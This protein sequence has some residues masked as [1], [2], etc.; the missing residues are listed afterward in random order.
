M[1]CCQ[2]GSWRQGQRAPTKD[3]RFSFGGRRRSGAARELGASAARAQRKSA[4]GPQALPSRVIVLLD[5]GPL[6][7]LS[8]PNVGKNRDLHRWVRD[9]I[10]NDSRV[11]VP[12]IADYEV[13][14]E[15]IRADKAEG[16]GKLDALK[17]GILEYLPLTT[18]AMERAARFWAESRQRGLPTC[19]ARCGRDSRRASGDSSRRGQRRH[20]YDECGR[21]GSV[22]C[23]EA[24]AGCPV[25][26]RTETLRRR[27]ERIADANLLH[28]T[29]PVP[30]VPGSSV[31][32]AFG[33]NN[34][35]SSGN[36]RVK[37]G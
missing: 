17:L 9:L 7:M 29:G 23:G 30:V 4:V 21:P 25:A 36:R 3:A 33:C 18:R 26:P 32:R 19:R 11:V 12:E 1:R 6:G 37:S 5:A 22:R 8:H 28:Y 20:R 24:V 15:L 14:R 35:A 10:R 13:R 2:A 31:G 27:V 16:L 34:A